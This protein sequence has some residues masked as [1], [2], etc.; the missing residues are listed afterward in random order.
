M[1]STSRRRRGTTTSDTLVIRE[2]TGWGRFVR[3]TMPGSRDRLRPPA[4]RSAPRR[5][6]CFRGRRVHRT[7]VRLPA[8]RV[9]PALSPLAGPARGA[10]RPSRVQQ[11]RR[12]GRCRSRGGPRAAAASMPASRE[13]WP[14]RAQERPRAPVVPADPGSGRA[15]P[16]L[17]TG[18]SRRPEAPTSPSPPIPPDGTARTRESP[19][20][21]V[22]NRFPYVARNFAS[23]AHP[24][25]H[26][27]FCSLGRAPSQSPF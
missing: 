7:A 15:G 19:A 11:D 20:G 14:R 22:R 23:G 5:R 17:P 12:R 1:F 2:T 6:A 4:V 21:A 27:A 18:S 13:K 3:Q 16:P 24:A 9:A 26:G 10:F 8:C 25:D